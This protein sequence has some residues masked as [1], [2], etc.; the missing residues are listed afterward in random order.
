MAAQEQVLVRLLGP[1]EVLAGGTPVGPAGNRRRAL[2]AMLALRANDVVSVADLVDGLWGSA[3]PASAV[4]VVQ[5]YVSTWRKA[6]GSGRLESVGHGYRLRLRTDECDLLSFQDLVDDGRR[7]SAA[8]SVAIGRPLLERALALWRGPPLPEL[9]GEPFYADGVRPVR[10]RRWQALEDWAGMSLESGPEVDLA[11]VVTA[12]D[13]A[14][15]EEP[16]RERLTELL[17][18]ALV[19]QGRQHAALEL[20]ADTQRALADEL[21]ADPGAGLR[22]MHGRVLRH[23]PSLVGVVTAPARGA[24]PSIR[25][26]SFVG[27]EQ[28][29]AVVL[30]LLAA[31]RLVSLTGPGGAGKTRLAEVVAAAWVARSGEPSAVVELASVEDP[32]LVTGTIAARLGHPSAE[33]VGALVALLATGPFLLVLDNVEHLPATDALVAALLQGTTGLRILLT[34]RQPLRI[35]GE[36]QYAVQPLLVPPPAARDVTAAGGSAAVR[37]LVD[38]AR[39]GDPEFEVTEANAGVLGDIVRRLDGL[40]LA[41]EIVAPWLK[42]LTPDGVLRQLE[43]P[44]DIPGRTNDGDQRHRTLR[45]AIEW[46]YRRLDADA[47]RLLTR[48]SVFRGGASLAALEA[49]CGDRPG[50]P[51]V[52]LLVELVDRSLVQ[53]APPAGG[54]PRFRLL[55]TIRSYAA[56]RLAEDPAELRR[57]EE[58]AAD[59]FADWA[60]GLAAHSEGP[61]T[62]RWL[63]QAIA[64]A[65]NLR[66]A[67]DHWERAGRATDHLQLVVDTMVLYFEAGQEREGER[68][69]ELALAAAPVEAPARAIGLAYLAWFSATHDRR[70]AA[71]RAAEAVT[72]ARAADDAPVLAFALQTLA[73]TLDDFAAAT[74]AGVEAG[75][76]AERVGRGPVRYGPTAGDAVACGAAHT[77]AGLWAHR[78]LPTALAHQE[79]A[80]TLAELEGD[81]RITAVNAARLGLLHLL[82]GDD[83]AAARPIARAVSLMTDPLSARWEDIVAFAEAQ[84]ARHEGRVG[85][86]EQRLT[87]LVDSALPSGRM[88]HVQLGSCSLTD[89]LVDQG[90]PADADA[91][92]RRAEAVV[93]SGD[94][95]RARARLQVRRARLLR[96]DGRRTAAEALLVA[97]QAGLE[98][99]ELTSERIVWFVEA[100]VGAPP[101][102][103][104]RLVGR[105]GGEVRRTGVVLPPWELRQLGDLADDLPA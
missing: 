38:R 4:G 34:T 42:A 39:A 90:R 49:V 66:A 62:G 22:D 24:G 29:L 84:L 15:A 1:L 13:E 57:T 102:R 79:R 44:L 103:A 82:G 80:L 71:E 104:R 11:A 54:I 61:D 46:S 51:V 93:A 2:F 94:D 55:E 40:P 12:L 60:V 59:W 89:L 83:A 25:L 36:Q 100:A 101:D 75:E 68:R 14:R 37:L 32:A 86:A 73:D 43:Q 5:T 87:S 56:G 33:T 23:D 10:E 70:R 92:L 95:A 3:P 64:D 72:I 78:S 96:L 52:P 30:E 8:G 21:G 91:A 16:W 99:D 28:D 88:L 76:V 7:A 105:L 58:R 97:A 45:D 65:D 48:M 53:P 74:A 31:H 9:S 17:M 77:L 85:E 63:A 19:R 41:V 50:P 98:E 27:R 26:D 20:Y 6:V 81:R 35:P 18:W 47:R 69:L 67:I